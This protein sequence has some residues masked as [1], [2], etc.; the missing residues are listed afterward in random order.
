M[1]MNNKTATFT[2]KM[3]KFKAALIG[4]YRRKGDQTIYVEE[5]LETFSGDDRLIIK[6][7]I[8]DFEET[9]KLCGSFANYNKS[10][11][12]W[13]SL[14]N[15]LKEEFADT[16]D[17]YSV[18][19]EISQRK[20]TP[21]QSYQGYIDIALQHSRGVLMHPKPTLMACNLRRDKMGSRNPEQWMKWFEELQNTE[22]EIYAMN[23]E[24]DS[25]VDNVEE[26]EH[27]TDTSKR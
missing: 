17:A 4:V 6:K 21:N 14:K 23:D 24:S 27:D 15:A 25:E 7:W 12:I 18:Y 22:N 11:K 8:R 9:V 1:Q 10:A 20:K 16:V 3:K 2:T 13:R 5:T 26:N 19:I